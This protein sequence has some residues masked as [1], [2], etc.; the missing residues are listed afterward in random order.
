MLISPFAMSDGFKIKSTQPVW[1]ALLGIPKKE[2]EFCPSAKV[3][4]PDF[5]IAGQPKSEFTEKQRR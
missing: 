3:I 4:P 2:A 1:M 5:L